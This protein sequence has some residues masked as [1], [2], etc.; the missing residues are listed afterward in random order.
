MITCNF[1]NKT[2]ALNKFFY[3][4]GNKYPFISYVSMSFVLLF[5]MIFFFNQWS[6]LTPTNSSKRSN[7]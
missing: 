6:P 4:K 2:K 5:F 7:L 3:K 1:N